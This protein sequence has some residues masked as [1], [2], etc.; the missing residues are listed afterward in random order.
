MCSKKKTAEA[1]KTEKQES[2]GA[3][4]LAKLLTNPEVINMLKVLSKTMDQINKQTTE[5]YDLQ[6]R[7]QICCIKLFVRRERYRFIIAP[8]IKLGVFL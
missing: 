5:Q 1:E 7:I 8:S 3:E 2:M 4:Q 6:M